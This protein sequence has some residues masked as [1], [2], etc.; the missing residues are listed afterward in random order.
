MTATTLDNLHCGEIA[1]VVEI[2]A[3]EALHQRLLALGFRSGRQI[4]L[5]RKASFSGPLQVRIGTTDILLRLNEAA[6]IKVCQA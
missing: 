4:E 2:H 6:K 5:I 1:T 3:E